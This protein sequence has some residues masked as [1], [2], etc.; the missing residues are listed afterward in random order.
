MRVSRTGVLWHGLVA[1]L[2]GY[3]IFAVYFAIVNVATGR[4]A[5]HTVGSLGAALL[6]AGTSAGDFGFDA[7]MAYNA[8]HLGASVLTGILSSFVFMQVERVPATWYVVMFFFIAGLLYAT[9]IGGIAAG[10]IATVVPWAHVVIV[11]LLA[12]VG[13]GSYLWR[14]HPGLADRVRRAAV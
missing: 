6:G 11:N 4:S 14:A 2:I 10:E 3:A 12:A 7:V 13:A 9:V 8:V 5:L 1:G